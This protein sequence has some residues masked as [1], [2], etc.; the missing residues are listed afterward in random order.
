MKRRRHIEQDLQRAV[1][2]H[3]DA[4]SARGVF[5]FH[6]A[7]GGWRSKIEAKILKGMG[8]RPGV[9]DVIAIKAGR[10]CALE[11]KSEHGRL[12]P[13]QKETIDALKQA[14]AVVAVADN[15]DDALDKLEL[16]GVLRG[17]RQ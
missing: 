2:Q 11:L 17:E 14:G 15:L 13:A 4:R 6:P 10:V 7:N 8:V 12:S 5:A 3:I 1:F 9:P 16:W